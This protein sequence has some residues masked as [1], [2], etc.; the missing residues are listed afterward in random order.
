MEM[1]ET[2]ET[3]QALVGPILD[4]RNAFLIDVGVRHERGGKLVQVFA[5]TDKGITIEECALISRE[6]SA[7]LD[8]DDVI[9]GSYR[10]EV[11]SP[12]ADRPLKLLRQY[13]KNV[14]R[15]FKVVYQQAGARVSVVGTLE[16]VHEDM[17][18]FQSSTGETIALGFSAIIEST[19]VLPW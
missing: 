1:R 4:Q 2:K 6:L 19:V 17:L 15:K 3:V 11:S 8:R 10:L 13:R 9:D 18:T 7:A 14:G 5:D 12:G 16:S